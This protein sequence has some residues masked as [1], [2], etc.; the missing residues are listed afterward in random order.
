M[1]NQYIVRPTATDDKNFTQ[2]VSTLVLLVGCPSVM[3]PFVSHVSILGLDEK[4][5]A[6]LNELVHKGCVSLPFD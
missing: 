3:K 2:F 1:L 6:K 4:T 5:G